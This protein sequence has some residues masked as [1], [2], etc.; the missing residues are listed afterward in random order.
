LIKS[1]AKYDLSFENFLSPFLSICSERMHIAKVSYNNSDF[2]TGMSIYALDSYNDVE[3][4]KKLLAA[5]FHTLKNLDMAR[6]NNH[7]LHM[8]QSFNYCYLVKSLAL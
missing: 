1:G 6:L 3:M 4:K 7:V 8:T 5:T 2:S